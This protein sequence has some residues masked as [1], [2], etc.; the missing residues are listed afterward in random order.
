MALVDVAPILARHLTVEPCELRGPTLRDILTKLFE[1]NPQLRGYVLD[2]Q[3]V[4]R[5]HVVIFVDGSAVRD[6]ASST[7]S[8]TEVIVMQALSGG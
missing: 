7:E 5:K 8:A 4:L 3:G 2:D 1:R 6:L